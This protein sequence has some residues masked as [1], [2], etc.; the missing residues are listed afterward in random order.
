MRVIDTDSRDI[1]LDEKKYKNILIYNIS[2]KTFMGS[3]PLPISFDEKDRFTKIYDRIRCVVLFGDGFY[4]EIFDRIKYLISKKVLLPIVL[5]IILQE[6]ELI[7]IM[8]Y[9]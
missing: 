2:Y 9:S 3:N 5:T 4:D 6:S 7:K 1:L 8:F